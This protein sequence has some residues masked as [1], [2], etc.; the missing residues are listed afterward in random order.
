MGSGKAGGTMEPVLCL[1]SGILKAQ[2]NKEV[3][4]AIFFD[5]EMARDTMWKEGLHIKLYNMGVGKG[6]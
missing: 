3:V 1:E 4:V 5:V 6:F 2:A